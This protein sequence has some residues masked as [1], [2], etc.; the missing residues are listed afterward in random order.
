MQVLV[1]G[2]TGFIGQA[3]LNKFEQQGDAVIVLTRQIGVQKDSANI[4]Y[5]NAL[6]EINKHDKIDA[7][8]N[9]AGEP[10]ADKRWSAEQKQR[11]LHSRVDVTEQ[12]VALIRRLESPP[13]CLLSA[14]A[15]GYYGAQDDSEDTR[16]LDEQAEAHDEFT[17]RL[18]RRWEEVAGQ[19][20]VSGVRV[21]VM[22]FGIVLGQGGGALGKMLPAFR[23]GFGGKLGNGEQVMSWI[24]RN[25]VIAAIDYLMNNNELSGVFNLTAP[26][27]VTNAEFT[28]LLGR[29]LAKPTMFSM[30]GFVVKLLFGEMGERLLL[31]GQ[32]VVPKRLLDNGFA[33]QYEHLDDALRAI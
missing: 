28:K 10:I 22:R 31:H 24:H 9:L 11:L 2:G 5:I 8:I 15:I 13:E 32:R 18:C 20:E 23:F 1:T 17:H 7:I 3:L 25:D 30:P 12:L 21:C 14:S 26:H 33:F 29:A 19:A 4:R 6:D 27:P 16:A